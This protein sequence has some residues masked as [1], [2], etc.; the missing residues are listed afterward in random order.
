LEQLNFG[1]TKRPFSLRFLETM[2]RLTNLFLDHHKKD[3]SVISRLTGLTKLG[4]SGITMP[5]LSL[6]L[7]LKAVRE[8]CIFLGGTANLGLLPRLQSLELLRLMRINKLSDL[9]MLGDLVG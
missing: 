9:G 7:P 2:P 3:L 8:L 6:L 5:D 4:L 1:T